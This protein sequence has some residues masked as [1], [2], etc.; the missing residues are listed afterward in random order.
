MHKRLS[1]PIEGKLD[2][3]PSRNPWLPFIIL[4]GFVAWMIVMFLTQQVD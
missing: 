4:T 3:D 1:L 2:Q